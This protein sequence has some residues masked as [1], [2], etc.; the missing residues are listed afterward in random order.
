MLRYLASPATNSSL[1]NFSDGSLPTWS[2]GSAEGSS[3]FKAP[4]P[5]LRTRE[6]QIGPLAAKMAAFTP[7]SLSEI[8][9]L[10]ALGRNTQLVRAEQ[11][12][13][14]EGSVTDHICLMVE[15]MACRY[16]FLS[17]GRRQILG[18]LIPGDLCDT[19]YTVFNRADHSLAALSD[20]KIVRIPIEKISVMMA[21][22][23]RIATA[24]SLASLVD[25]AVLR[26]W[27][28]NVGQR[29]AVQRL[30]HF[31]CEMETRLKSVGRVACDGSFDL[32]V[33]QTTIADTIGLTAVH[34]NR[35]L[36]RLRQAGLI[37]LRHRRLTVLDRARL[38]ELA[39]FDENYLHLRGHRV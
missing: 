34:T 22:Y 25:C 3:R 31:I 39:S 10:E 33:N 37:C 11:V 15:G 27:L 14:H 36:Q 35:I 7:L 29:D 6:G 13:I 32:P 24:L 18:Y 2:D 20:S 16:K 23:P 30:G 17:G 21:T 9:A 4:T 12:I 8:E 1:G 38:V 26:E 28:L 5:A 19:H